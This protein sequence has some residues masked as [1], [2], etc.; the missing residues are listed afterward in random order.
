MRLSLLTDLAKPLCATKACTCIPLIDS[1]LAWFKRA[2]T[3]L[4]I[5]IFFI[6]FFSRCIQE[7]T[8]ILE[9][10]VELRKKVQSAGIIIIIIIIIIMVNKCNLYYFKIHTPCYIP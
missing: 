7:N 3:D 1:E 6:H 10:L 9:E 5:K 2:Q 4:F 8:P